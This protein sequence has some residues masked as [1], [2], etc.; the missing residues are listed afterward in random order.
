M[1]HEFT[2]TYPLPAG[3]DVDELIERLGAAGCTDALIGTGQLGHIAL[4]FTSKAESDAIARASVTADIR[5]AAP[6]VI[7]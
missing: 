1:N 3:C 5:M 7:S 2:M 6:E 4:Q